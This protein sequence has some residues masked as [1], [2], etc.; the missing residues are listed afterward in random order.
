MRNRSR[1]DIIPM[2]LEAA[3]VGATKTKIM[4]KA[5]LSYAQ[6]IEYLEYLQQSDLLTCEECTQLY[7]PTEKGLKFLNL[8][9][10]INELTPDIY[11][12]N[13]SLQ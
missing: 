3:R 5:Y 11:T 13:Y 4:Y 9:N 10:E 2:I 12:K 8:S 7:R 1:S 6:V